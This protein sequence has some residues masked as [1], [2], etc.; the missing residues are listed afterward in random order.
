MIIKEKSKGNDVGAKQKAD[1]TL[2]KTRVKP[3]ELFLSAFIYGAASFSVF[4]LLGILGFVFFKGYKMLCPDFFINVTSPRRGTVGIGGNLLNTAYL[5][6]MALLIGIPVGVGAAIYLNEYAVQGKL[7]RAVEFAIETLAGIPSI[8]FGMFGMVF[9]GGVLGLGYSLLNG[10]LTLTLMI[11]SLIVQNTRD[12]LRSV[13]ES[14]RE[15][16]VGMGAAKWHMI[17][18][19]L[20]PSAMPGIM[21]GIILAVGRIVG[22]SAALLFTAGSAGALPRLGQGIGEDVAGLFGKIFDSGGTLAIALYL[23]MQNGEYELAFG[24]GCVLILVVLLMNCMI[25]FIGAKKY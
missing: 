2:Y 11:L 15:G 20:L 13:P 23:Q 24:I 14:Y 22:E 3:L 1:N 8:L 18:T 4:L 5:I 16:A 17:R 10:A 21:T 6:V 7:V 25:S 9:F 12:A 19:V